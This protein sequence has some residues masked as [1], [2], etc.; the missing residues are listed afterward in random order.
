MADQTDDGLC[1]DSA[2]KGAGEARVG[3]VDVVGGADRADGTASDDGGIYGYAARSVLTKYAPF[4]E[5]NAL[6]S[7]LVLSA[8][9]LEAAARSAICASAERLGYGRDGCSWAWI[10]PEPGLAG[11]SLKELVEGL[12]PIAIIATDPSA[13]SALAQA[14]GAAAEPNSISRMNGRA[15]VGLNEFETMLE[16]DDAKQLAWRLMKQLK[17]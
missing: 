17:L 11:E 6:D 13:L 3:G 15:V 9:P 10:S 1:V 12:D 7:L 4:V 8:S 16:N 5:G 14:Y 2:R